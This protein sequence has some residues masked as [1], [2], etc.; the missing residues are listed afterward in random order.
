MQVAPAHR[1]RAFVRLV[2]AG[3]ALL[4]VA[5]EVAGA[6]VHTVQIDGFAFK[7]STLTVKQGDTIVW[8]NADPLPHTVTSKDAGLGSGDIP[9]NG[10]YRV[11]VR[12]KGSFQYICTLH[13]IMKG[14]LVVE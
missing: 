14:E 11:T 3:V 1:M 7:P 9:A 8:H 4:A 13:P 5:S 10:N 2:A 12:K 6:T